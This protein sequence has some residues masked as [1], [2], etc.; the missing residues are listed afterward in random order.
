MPDIDERQGI[1]PVQPTNPGRPP[2]Q[3]RQPKRVPE[4]ERSESEPK[5]APDSGSGHVVDE[6]V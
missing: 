1:L 2:A 3:R 5:R 6:Y 4:R